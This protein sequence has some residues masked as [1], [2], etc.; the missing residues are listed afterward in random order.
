MSKEKITLTKDQT[1]Q[2]KKHRAKVINDLL[3]NIDVSGELAYFVEVGIT[4]ALDQRYS[5]AETKLKLMDADGFPKLADLIPKGSEKTQL[6][7]ELLPKLPQ[8][9]EDMLKK[10]DTEQLRKLKENL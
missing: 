6:I 7:R 8:F 1:E 4:R 3:E 9:T 5:T 2:W 10:L